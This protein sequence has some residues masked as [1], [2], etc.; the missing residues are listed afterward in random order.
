MRS[1]ESMPRGLA[2]VWHDPE[3]G[4]ATLLLDAGK[5]A[6]DIRIDRVEATS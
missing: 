1:D 3:S 5:P 6:Q 4:A 2:L